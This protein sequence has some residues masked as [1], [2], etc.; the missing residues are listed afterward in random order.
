[1]RMQNLLVFIK[2]LLLIK[3][4]FSVVSD[5]VE[6]VEEIAK[7]SDGETKKKIA[8]EML[9]NTLNLTNLADDQKKKILNLVS[10]LVDTVVAFKNLL[11]LWRN[12]KN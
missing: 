6:K 4:Y 11:N 7:A 8:M 5:V 1:M 2:Y 10:G 12:S 9:Q 3:K